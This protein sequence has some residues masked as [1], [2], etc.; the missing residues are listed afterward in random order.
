MKIYIEWVVDELAMFIFIFR[1]IKGV[2]KGKIEE[3]NCKFIAVKY[4]S[5]FNS[6]WSIWLN[7]E[8]ELVLFNIE[9]IL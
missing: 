7:G 4:I 1:L 2:T 6:E 9:L 5:N 8:D 3:S